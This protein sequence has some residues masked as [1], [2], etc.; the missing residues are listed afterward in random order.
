[1]KLE[2][3]L[4][5]YKKQRKNAERDVKKVE[6]KYNTRLKK[7]VREILKRI[8]ALERKEVP[9]D[10]ED[11][12]KKIV[13]AE[14]RNYVI[15][16]RRA[17]ESLETM[18]DLGKRLPD[19]AKLHVGHG[20]YLLL[21]FEKDVYAINRLLKKLN[22]DYV[23]Y[24]EKVSKKS[25]GELN[26]EGLIENERE[27][28]RKIELIERER[29]ELREKVEEKK[30]ELEEFH[31]EHG[32]DELE[33]RIKELSSKVRSEE[34]EVRS[35]ASKLQ[36]P[37]KRMRL[38]EEIASNFV[39]DSSYALKKPDE[40]I[41]LLQRIYPQLEGKHRKTAQWLIEN[42]KERAEAIAEERRLLRELK[43]R[44]DEILD[45]ASSKEKE[46]WELE[47]LIKEKESEIRKLKR[48]LEHLEKELEKSIKQLEEIL[49][50]KI[51]R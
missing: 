6:K 28:R 21:I 15:S 30:K 7:K 26:I 23:K 45:H 9:K 49:G 35:K 46:I 4:R 39:G 12:I 33:K 2:Q 36:K 19:L 18:D 29:D 41:S 20:K 31:R 42:L 50:E 51:E 27:T 8:D 10:V 22:E 5:E 24:Y 11:R 25:L 17:L 47:R 13:T 43:E 34:L 14:K 40:F 1:M 16:L 37:I 44:K 38:H 48:Q 3:A 32:L